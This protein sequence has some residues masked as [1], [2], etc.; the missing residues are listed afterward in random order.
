[1]GHELHR[2]LPPL[3]P[4]GLLQPPVHHEAVPVGGGICTSTS[5]SLPR[6]SASRRRLRA[7][8]SGCSGGAS[9]GGRTNARRSKGRERNWIWRSSRA[10]TPP[11]R[12]E[13]RPRRPFS[14]FPMR[15]VTAT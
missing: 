5:Y 4:H 13:K 14:A 1:Q 8:A 3:P 9:T 6:S 2:H 11:S 7:S 12:S 15:T 10:S